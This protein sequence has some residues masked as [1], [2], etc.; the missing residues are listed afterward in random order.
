MA[1]VI[2]G[3]NYRKAGG[4]GRGI[5]GIKELE[6]CSKPGTAGNSQAEGKREGEAIVAGEEWDPTATCSGI[7]DR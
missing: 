6:Q 1:A 4:R 7:W 5:L 2:R 3:F